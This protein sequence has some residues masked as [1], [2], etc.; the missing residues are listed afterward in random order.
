MGIESEWVNVL[1]KLFME[2]FVFL[3]I[4]IRIELSDKK[5]LHGQI[6]LK[7]KGEKAL[8]LDY[9][10]ELMKNIECKLSL[11]LSITYFR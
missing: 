7:F 1:N 6:N 8:W 11:L 4:L 10:S 5:I 9:N 3:L 2:W